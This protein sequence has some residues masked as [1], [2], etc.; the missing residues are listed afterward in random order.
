MRCQMTVWRAEDI[1]AMSIEPIE[2]GDIIID[3]FDVERIVI[4]K[5]DNCITTVPPQYASARFL[6]EYWKWKSECAERIKKTINERG[7]R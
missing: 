4:D 3:E 6:E 1:R 2:P 7:V 5:S